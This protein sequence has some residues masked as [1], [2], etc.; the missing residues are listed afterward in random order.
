MTERAVPCLYYKIIKYPKNRRD[1]LQSLQPYSSG[2]ELQPTHR[3][4][5]IKE[6]SGGA[7]A[8]CPILDIQ[9]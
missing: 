1:P 8:Q 4:N 2:Y 6:I 7:L 5:I 3:T 9:F